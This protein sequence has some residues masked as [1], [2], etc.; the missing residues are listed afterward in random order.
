MKTSI[1]FLAA[2]VLCAHSAL[3][4]PA[5]QPTERKDLQLFNDVAKTVNRYDRFTIFDDVSAEVKDG[6]VTL[7]GKVTMP[8]KSD[9]IERRVSKVD[10]VREVRNRITVLPVSMMDDQEVDVHLQAKSLE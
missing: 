5:A 1:S 10:G 8:Y 4:Q 3:A 9:D 2:L 6:V 7:T